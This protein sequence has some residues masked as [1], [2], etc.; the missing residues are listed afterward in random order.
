MLTM[1]TLAATG[2]STASEL[3]NST[4]VVVGPVTVHSTNGLSGEWPP[5]P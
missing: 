4:T 1:A 5:G 3:H 2:T